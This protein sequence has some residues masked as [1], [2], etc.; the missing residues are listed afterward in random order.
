M[1]HKINKLKITAYMQHSSRA[2]FA[3]FRC[4]NEVSSNNSDIKSKSKS[5]VKRGS[6]LP[7]WL[8]HGPFVR[9]VQ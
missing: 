7:L 2:V 3:V 5:K 6:F 1:L 8:H 4:T 9:A